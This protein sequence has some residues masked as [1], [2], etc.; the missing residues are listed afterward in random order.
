[1]SAARP[2]P[3]TVDEAGLAALRAITLRAEAARRLDLGSSEAVLRA[4]I[5]ATVV[6]FDATAASLALYEAETDR[7]VFRVAAGEQGEGVIG[8]SI[9]PDQG[10]AGYVFTTGQGL[11]IADV[12]S[13]RRF[14]RQVAEQTR[15][16]PTSIAAV[17]LVDETGT[18]GV[19]EVL[20]K[21]DG[22]TFTLRDVELAGVFA[23]QAAVAI[24]ASRVERDTASLLRSVLRSIAAAEGDGEEVTPDAVEQLVRDA[25]AEL[26]RRDDSSLWRLADE[27]ARIRGADPSQVSLVA[28]L[29]GVVGQH[30]VRRARR[31]ARARSPRRAGDDDT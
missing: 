7:L 21:R 18:I 30:A 23:R 12:A 10:L 4:I 25:A 1:M 26:D 3:T 28:D 19:L 29:L 27:V 17:P 9:P 15:Y 22:T 20:D 31:V 14:G 24:A 8:L 6:L 13:D 11:A 16:V 2:G 5:E